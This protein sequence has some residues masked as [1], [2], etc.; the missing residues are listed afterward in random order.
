MHMTDPNCGMSRDPK[1][2]LLIGSAK[3]VRYR[4]LKPELLRGR[5]CTGPEGEW[6]R[7]RYAESI[8]RRKAE[9]EKEP[10]K[11]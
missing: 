10:P 3:A 8:R 5:I 1:G 11:K 4:P 7:R 9:R 6:A 2:E